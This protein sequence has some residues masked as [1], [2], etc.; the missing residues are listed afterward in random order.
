MSD[1]E[2]ERVVRVMWTYLGILAFIVA[3]AAVVCR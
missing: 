1:D 2:A 3:V